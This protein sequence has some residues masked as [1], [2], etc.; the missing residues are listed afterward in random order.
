MVARRPSALAWPGDGGR[1]G[2]GGKLLM[3]FF[4]F[5]WRVLCA[6]LIHSLHAA[7]SVLLLLLIAAGFFTYFVPQVH[8]MID[9]HGWQ[10]AAIVLGS[11]VGIRLVLAPYWIW[12][13][14]QTKISCL[15]TQAAER[16]DAA[17]AER[18]EKEAAIDEITN[19][20]AWAI[21]NL[22]NQKPYPL[23]TANPGAAVAAL[24]ARHRLW[25][26]QVAKKLENRAV[27]NLSDQT[28]FDHLGHIQTIN[29][30][31]HLQF[32][33]LQSML[34]LQLERLREIEDRARRRL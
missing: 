4:K 32:D 3:D 1:V 29:M 33:H 20:I 14:D 19:E 17:A 24:V 21:D 25:T 27:F 34:K 28:H 11:I 16:K 15:E 8:L 23:N 12:K 30:T 5:Y 13:E 7:H 9:L 22:V 18:A 10:I 6:A 2:V 26:E 31:Q